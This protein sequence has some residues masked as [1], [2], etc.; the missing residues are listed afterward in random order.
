MAITLGRR[1]HDNLLI[2]VL[3]VAATAVTFFVAGQLFPTTSYLHAL[4]FERSWIQY[5]TMLVFWITIAT[6]LVKHVAHRREMTAYRQARKILDAPDFPSMLI[7]SDADFVRGKFTDASVTPYQGSLTFGR[8]VNALDRLRKAQSTKAMEEYFRT[9]GEFDA[10]EHETAYTGVRYCVWLIPT[11]GFLGTV[12]GIGV[13]ISRFA[14]M[15][16]NAQNFKAVQKA[17]P[18]VTKQLG[19][20]FD[21]T[22]LALVLSALAVFYMSYLTKRQ[23]QF[24]E[25]L[26]GLCLDGVCSVFQEHSTASEQVVRALQENVEELTRRMNGN[27]GAIEEVLRREVPQL[28]C[29]E[30]VP[31]LRELGETF[32]GTLQQ[33]AGA[34]AQHSAARAETDRQLANDVRD[35][36]LAQRRVSEE[37]AAGRQEVRSLLQHLRRGET[38]GE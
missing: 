22:L 3:A 5:A 11:L 19:T 31:A 4:F 36:R 12:L 9:R 8:I 10:A 13:G 34:A 7:W 32:G 18:A 27:R 15:I 14:G 24:L 1:F 28:I 29:Y 20:A 17:L 30:L 33:I 21:T 16:Q 6:L 2:P 23:E 37:V 35:V 38:P 26:D 25:K